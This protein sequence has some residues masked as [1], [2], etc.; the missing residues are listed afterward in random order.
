MAWQL[1]IFI[2]GTNMEDL[3]MEKTKVLLVDDE[4]IVR[5]SISEWLADAGYDVTPAEDGFK[6]IEIIRGR[7]SQADIMVVDLKMPG[8]DGIEVM[9]EAKE[10]SP[11]VR[12]I[13]ITAYGTVENAVEAMKVGAADYLTKPFEPE[14]LENAI[15]NVIKTCG[16]TSAGIPVVEAEKEGVA[17][18]PET[19]IAKAEEFYGKKEFDL[20]IGM[21]QEAL[22]LDPA[23]IT[24][25]KGIVRA[26]R[27]KTY[28]NPALVE[29][30]EKKE[31][32]PAVKQCVWAKLGV[33]SYRVCT[34]N[35]KCEICE[36][37]QSMMDRED[38]YEDSGFSEA[39]KKL[40]ALPAVDRKCRYMLSGD[41][42]HKLCPNL[43]SCGTCG[44]DQRMQDV[45]DQKILQ[46]TAKLQKKA[47]KTETA[48]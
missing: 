22:K 4:A 41:V 9:R 43:Y 5:D 17:I 25:K 29:T 13:I 34:N 36:F 38:G 8:K 21:F 1:L 24:A 14:Q 15:R 31:S 47:A 32:A 33:V 23:A 35:F 44:Y 48:G 3:D 16:G 30:K 28:L 42:T 20:A 37:A 27:Q 40:L 18:T 10:L 7:Q 46:M 12:V 26:E 11:D 2:S 39:K 19:C 6:A 45:K